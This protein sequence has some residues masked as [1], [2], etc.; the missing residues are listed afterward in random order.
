M[1]SG[2]ALFFLKCFS[3][4]SPPLSLVSGQVAS[5]A[6]REL[7]QLH[8]IARELQDVLSRMFVARSGYSSDVAA[9]LLPGSNVVGEP[10]YQWYEPFDYG[11]S[12]SVDAALYNLRA[13]E[14]IHLSKKG[15]VAAAYSF[16]RVAALAILYKNRATTRTRAYTPF[17]AG[18]PGAAQMRITFNG[19]I[20][21]AKMLQQ[22]ERLILATL[23]VAQTAPIA[24]REL[25]TRLN[26]K[27]SVVMDGTNDS[28]A[29]TMSAS[30][31]KRVIGENFMG[32]FARPGLELAM[33]RYM[34]LRLE[35]D[36]WMGS[37][38]AAPAAGG[39]AGGGAAAGGGGG[40]GVDP[41]ACWCERDFGNRNHSLSLEHI[42]PRNV[43][44]VD[45]GDQ[46]IAELKLY[47][48]EGNKMW[49]LGNLALLEFPVSCLQQF[50]FEHH[51]RKHTHAAS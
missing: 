23:L 11:S 14:H 8:V 40:G 48:D 41:F 36:A 24:K 15:T 50:C 10:K 42:F 46:S 30:A 27:L 19:N 9:P 13:L 17:A 21:A 25:V 20:G 26:N 31:D 33:A 43:G 37:R 3:A 44:V 1:S 38:A 47:Y 35:R 49:D 4:A 7:A 45:L 2:G 51:A 16:W 5:N 12:D 18:V 28:A 32:P 6:Q 29:S 22:L 39:G 34:L